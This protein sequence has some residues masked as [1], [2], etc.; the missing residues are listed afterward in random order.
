MHNNTN[1]VNNIHIVHTISWKE[2]EK[3][4]AIAPYNVLSKKGAICSCI[5][6]LLLLE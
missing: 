2:S 5:I 4:E 3:N 1:M 6:S